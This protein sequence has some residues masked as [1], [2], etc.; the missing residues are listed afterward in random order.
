MSI[1]RRFDELH[2]DPNAVTDT[3]YTA[4][5]NEIDVE[6]TGDLTN[7]WLVIRVT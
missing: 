1:V 5:H 3:S 4:F 2:G 6:F 7:G